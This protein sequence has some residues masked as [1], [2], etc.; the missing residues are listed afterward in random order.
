MPS[1]HLLLLPDSSKLSSFLCKSRGRSQFKNTADKDVRTALMKAGI[2]GLTKVA[3][4]SQTVQIKE[5]T[6]E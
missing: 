5:A 1:L 4:G 6:H 3:A 2:M